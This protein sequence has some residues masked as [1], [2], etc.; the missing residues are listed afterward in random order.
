MYA[1]IKTGGK[2]YRVEKDSTVTVDLLPQEEGSAFETDQVLLVKSGENE[3]QV[4]SPLVKDAKVTG[5]VLSHFKGKKV[6]IFKKKRRKGY[7]RKTGHRQN[8]TKLQIT[9]IQC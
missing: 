3:Y 2:Q 9:N 1:I 6:V 7:Q 8:Y 4:G 5:T